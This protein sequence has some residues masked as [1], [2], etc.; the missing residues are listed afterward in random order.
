[1]RTALS[2]GV[3]IRITRQDAVN[4]K[5]AR[6]DIPRRTDQLNDLGDRA[7]T[8]LWNAGNRPVAALKTVVVENA[9]TQRRTSGVALL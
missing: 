8:L 1:M 2:P 4:Y 3:L 6:A 9:T 7:T 5:T